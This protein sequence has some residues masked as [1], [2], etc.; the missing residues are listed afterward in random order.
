MVPD[1]SL[2]KAHFICQLPVTCP[3][4][5]HLTPPPPCPPL[6]PPTHARHRRFLSSHCPQLTTIS[7]C[8]AS[9]MLYGG[10]LLEASIISLVT[11]CH[12]LTRLSL[13]NVD[14]TDKALTQLAARC[15]C[16][17]HLALGR[18]EN[19]AFGNFISGEMTQRGWSGP[20]LKPQEGELHACQDRNGVLRFP[21]DGSRY[22]AEVLGSESCSINLGSTITAGHT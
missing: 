4:L 13:L 11:G 7:S 8:F 14:V 1:G 3:F 6:P 19:N 10:S 20:L 18:T 9:D 22:A 2:L 21:I 15:P 12:Q 5:P 16:L 17:R